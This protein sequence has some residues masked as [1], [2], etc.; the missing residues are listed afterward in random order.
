MHNIF[1]V[2]QSEEQQKY[3]IELL[4]VIGSLSKL[5]SD[6]KSP[7]LYYRA[8]ENLFCEV[9]DAKNL[10]RGDVSYDAIKNGVGIGLKT[11]LHN[12]GRTF[13]KVAEFNASSNIFRESLNEEDT[14]YKVADLRNK[15]LKITKN[16]TNA[17][18]AIYH[19]ITRENGLMNIFEFPMEEID[20]DSI[21][22]KKNKNNN[23][24]HFS[25][26]Y[27]EYTFSLSKNT[28][29]K[30][31]IT[32]PEFAIRKFNVEILENPFEILSQLITDEISETIAL[33]TDEQLEA[34]ILPL[35]S[36][37]DKKVPPKSGL[38]Q[39]NASGRKRHP[40]EVYIPIP[41]WIH[42]TFPD[43]FAFSRKYSPGKSA[44]DSPTF[45]VE[46]PNQKIMQCKVAQQGGKAL[47]SNPNKD[48]GEWI[49]R[50]VLQVSRGTLVTME[51]LNEIGI[52]SVQLSKRDDD[53]YILDFMETGS[54]DEFELNN[55]E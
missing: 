40:D 48:L 19:L 31:F 10:S 22:L 38:N 35:Y 29:L 47:M 30:R 8:H 42:T 11:F 5:F 13:Q 43:F 39:W 55:E 28:L 12:N 23:T 41:S 34:I 2:D 24:I 26:K 53:Y 51:L 54:F 3:Y 6:S 4:K 27:N 15:R 17:K 32:H 50:E 1:W 37:R 44:S 46:L 7:Y 16:A 36:V 21:K 49:L 20:I 52:D 9:F 45:N 18:D 25:D 14:V 33:K